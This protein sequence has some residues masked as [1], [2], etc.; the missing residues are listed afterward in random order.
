MIRRPSVM[1]ALPSSNVSSS[2]WKLGLNRRRMSTHLLFV[3]I[4]LM[5]LRKLL[6][7]SAASHALIT[8]LAAKGRG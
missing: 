4:T 3:W 7:D 2:K 6:E 1:M 8:P 5:A